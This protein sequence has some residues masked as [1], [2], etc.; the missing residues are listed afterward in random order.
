MKLLI[1]NKYLLKN[2]FWVLVLTNCSPLCC[3]PV[4]LDYAPA[5]HDPGLGPLVPNFEQ[6]NNERIPAN[7]VCPAFFISPN[8]Q[9]LGLALV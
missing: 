3:N 1:N 6:E 2:N 4:L 8:A 7:C 5:V 9:A